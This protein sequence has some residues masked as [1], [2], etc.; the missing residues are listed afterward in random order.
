[1][2]LLQLLVIFILLTIYLFIYLC[3]V[4]E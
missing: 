4:G 1:L 3:E 2:L